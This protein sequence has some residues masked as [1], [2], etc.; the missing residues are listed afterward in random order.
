MSTPDLEIVYFQVWSKE[1][2]PVLEV[3]VLLGEPLEVM[4]MSPFSRHMLR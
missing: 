2:P 4:V 3:P 1:E